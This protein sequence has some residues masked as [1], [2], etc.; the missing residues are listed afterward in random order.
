[1]FDNAERQD[2]IEGRQRIIV[3]NLVDPVAKFFSTLWSVL[4]RFRER[5]ADQFD[6]DRWRKL[7][8]SHR[9]NIVVK[10]SEDHR[11]WRHFLIENE[12]GLSA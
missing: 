9:R 7:T 12:R 6:N 4:D 1:M 11:R 5:F 8:E 10:D 3:K 2:W